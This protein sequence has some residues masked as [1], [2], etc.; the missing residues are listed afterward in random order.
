M[1]GRI[2][3][4]DL[5]PVENGLVLLISDIESDAFCGGE[6][7]HNAHMVCIDTRDA[8]A[9]Y[10]YQSLPNGEVGVEGGLDGCKD[11]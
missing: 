5:V 8:I 3:G 2:G 11:W 7:D 4:K 9:F 6:Q 10:S 1:D